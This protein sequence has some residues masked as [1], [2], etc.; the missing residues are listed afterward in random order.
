MKIFTTALVVSFVSVFSM[1]VSAAPAFVIKDSDCNGFVPNPD[2]PSGF[3][4]IAGLFTT[5]THGV[6]AGKVGKATCHF[7]FDNDIVGLTSASSAKGW[8]CAIIDPSTGNM[9]STDKTLMLATPAGKALLR[10]TFS[11][12]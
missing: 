4:A 10:C 7:D 1:Q 3:P 6:N 12:P 11:Q 2:T 9:I 5:Q 8:E